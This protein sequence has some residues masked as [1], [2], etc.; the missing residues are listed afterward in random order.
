VSEPTARRL[1]DGPW[2]WI[3]HSAH[4]RAK[5]AAGANGLA[6]LTAFAALEPKGGGTFRASSQ[7]LAAASG[8]STR[9]VERLL[10]TLVSARVVALVSSGKSEGKGS[11]A[12]LANEWILL[13]VRNSVAESGFYAPTVTQSEPPSDTQT[14]PLPSA[15]HAELADQR[16]SSASE[17]R[18]YS[19][20]RKKRAGAPA[21]G[22]GAGTRGGK[23]RSTGQQPPD[24]QE[25]GIT[26]WDKLL[27]SGKFQEF[28]TDV[29]RSLKEAQERGERIQPNWGKGKAAAILERLVAEGEVS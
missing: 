25:T 4:L 1:K 22:A 3:S 2:I 9:S 6:L 27:A 14:E 19:R 16:G 28:A 7:N 11:G 23:P 13:R 12:N 18:G 8:L 20:R 5:G 17:Q 24:P 10:R 21:D 29:R 15:S 26:H